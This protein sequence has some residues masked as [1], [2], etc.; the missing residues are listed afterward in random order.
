MKKLEFHESLK[1]IP[2]MPLHE[3]DAL[4]DDIAK[5]KQLFPII[6]LGGKIIDGRNRYLACLSR[7]I[8]PKTIELNPVDT[9]SFIASANYFRKHWTTQERSHFAAMMSLSS[10]IGNPETSVETNAPNGAIRGVEPQIT[11]EKA[12]EVMGVSRRSVQRAKSKI[13]GTDKKTA[14]KVSKQQGVDKDVRDANGVPLPEAALPYWN[15]KTEV[16]EI[17]NQIHAAKRK[18]EGIPK[19]D[20]LYANVGLSGVV[21]DLKSAVNR[22]TAAI[23]AYVCPYCKGVKPDKCKPCKGKGVVSKYFWDTAVPKEMKPERPF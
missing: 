18:V 4:A 12:A 1:D 19:D 11:Q 13:K 2:L 7:N 10:E 22:L 15:R 23:P 8:E 5:H 9:G 3:R 6:L 14:S 16:T 21:S 20:P 17:I